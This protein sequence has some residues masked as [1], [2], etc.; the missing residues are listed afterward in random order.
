MNRKYNLQIG[1]R[2]ETFYYDDSDVIRVLESKLFPDITDEEEIR[3]VQRALE[4]P[5]DSAPL[6][7]MV[8]KGD[9]VCILF[10]D[11]TRLWVRHHVF[12]P[13]ILKELE[14]GE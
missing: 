14:R 3:V 11:A 9:R 13:F 2:E 1:D 10:S 8:K 12:M 6:H 5:I 7:Q 4:K